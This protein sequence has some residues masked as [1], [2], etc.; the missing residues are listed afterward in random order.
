MLDETNVDIVIGG[1]D[2]SDAGSEDTGSEESLATGADKTAQDSEESVDEA[3]LDTEELDDETIEALAEAYKDRIKTTK[4]LKNDLDKTVSQRLKSREAEMARTQT[5]EQ[6]LWQAIDNGA[7]AAQGLGTV[8]QKLSQELTK[9]SKQED[10]SATPV[11]AAE[12][13][14]AVGQLTG[15]VAAI[16]E[17]RVDD[18]V[19]NGVSLF[20]GEIIPALKDEHVDELGKIRNTFERMRS[21]PNQAGR[22]MSYLMKAMMGFAADR[23][24]EAGELKAQ[25]TSKTRKSLQEKLTKGN[26]NKAVAA[27]MAQGKSPP[28][29]PRSSGPER[30][31]GDFTIDDYRQAK[32]DGKVDL[33]NEIVGS[34]QRDPVGAP[35]GYR[36]IQSG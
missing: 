6:R 23:G 2:V 33:V 22:A 8:V 34:W 26:L 32:K 30:K 18:A 14:N 15:A 21:D 31:A 5:G 1:D 13:Q 25:A 3:E 16:Y 27:K 9:A 35:G 20:D 10:F 36:P 28:K 11:T 4:A 7:R 12:Y 29:A 17:A 24:L 19:D